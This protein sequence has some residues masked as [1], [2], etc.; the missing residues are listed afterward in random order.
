MHSRMGATRRACSGESSQPRR[1]RFLRRA[2]GPPEA[3]LL[4]VRW[5]RRCRLSYRDVEELLAQLGI[6]VAIARGS[7]TRVKRMTLPRSQ[8]TKSTGTSMAVTVGP[9]TSP[10]TDLRAKP[11]ASCVALPWRST[12]SVTAG[13]R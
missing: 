9:W 2:P 12:G 5:Y 4:A 10:P 3:I 1:V 8:L 11:T 13:H 7:T 6:D